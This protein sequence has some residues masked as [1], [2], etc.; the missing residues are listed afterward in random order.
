MPTGPRSWRRA[1]R[2]FASPLT[3]LRACVVTYVALDFLFALGTAPTPGAQHVAL[4]LASGGAVVVALWQPVVGA[5]ISAPVLASRFLV[6]EH[7]YGF[8]P[9]V[10][11]TIAVV[12][13]APRRAAA[14]VVSG[15]AAFVAAVLLR[16][17]DT[18][19]S[20]YATVFIVGI[21][22]GL[23]G[24]F[25]LGRT[26]LAAHRI[27]G[28][29]RSID[30][31]RAEERTALADE[32]AALL[33][34]GL[35]HNRGELERAASSDHPDEIHRLLAAATA[36]S[37]LALTRLRGLVATLRLDELAVAD[38]SAVLRTAVEEAEDQLVG[39]GHPVELDLAPDLSALEPAR[40]RALERS[41]RAGVEV[42]HAVGV[43][44]ATCRIEVTT[45]PGQ[46]GVRLS[47][48]VT[49]GS[50][51]A[52]ALPELQRAGLAA[53]D[54]SVQAG[55][56]PDGWSM[57]ALVPQRP[58]ASGALPSRAGAGSERISLR[59]ARL[60]VGIVCMVAAV[61]QM[62]ASLSAIAAGDPWA[63]DAIWVLT[64]VGI[65]V[66]VR[67]PLVG[68]ILLAGGMLAS[69][70]VST[71]TPKAWQPP[72][73][74]I[75]AIAAIWAIRSPRRLVAVA[76]AWLGYVLVWFDSRWNLADLVV[77][78]AYP[79]IGI[80]LGAAARYFMLT[81]QRQLAELHKLASER[82]DARAAERRQLA[83]ELH[84]VVAHQLS[85]MSMQ[86][87]AHA[88][89][90]DLAGLRAAATSMARLNDGAQADLATLL[91][92]MR[93]DRPAVAGTEVG[94]TAPSAVAGA[95][96][97]TLTDAG[98]A[99]DL[100]L[101]DGTDDCCAT[102]Q[103]TIAR[104]LREGSTNVMRYAPPRSRCSIRVRPDADSVS[105]EVTNPLAPTTRRH[106]DST[107]N[108]LRGLTERVL[109]TG[110]SFTAGDD[111]GRW[112]VRAVLPRWDIPAC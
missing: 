40:A 38:A 22:L 25:L 107:G 75:L 39:T 20:A 58:A 100:D 3:L 78:V 62:T 102:T 79:S 89:A 91:A 21:A 77:L 94:W 54:G 9:L 27:A 6:G 108:G 101:P 106:P 43:P 64:W 23:A 56:G 95:V 63:L 93:E 97:A 15:Y 66:A 28:L 86:A 103:R 76:I 55:S 4:A 68:T 80:M 67:A 70:W 61:W 41:L 10:V 17:T 36:S 45:P 32:L 34:A 51:V 99:V 92:L 37:R 33:T 83:G 52:E 88:E 18:A 19:A 13:A 31:I 98:Y 8:S 65:A 84:D 35:S 74:E 59:T 49:P 85:L 90:S 87:L 60:T 111:G 24:R 11:C 5:A 110:G 82:A 14:V 73:L 112:R 105:V 26:R 46:V 72:H 7:G 2:R 48:A 12:A 71:P 53:L 96:H 29:A 30:E 104:L 69:L 50:P 57:T 109:L 81:R 1:L 44:G 42:V 47:C 16:G